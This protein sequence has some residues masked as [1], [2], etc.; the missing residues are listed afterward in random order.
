MFITF[1]GI[2]GCGKSTQ[3]SLIAEF[4]E[5]KNKKV[6]CFREPGGTLLAEQIRQI[7]LNS[8]EHI[9]P[10]AELLL[11]NSARANLVEE[12]IKPAIANGYIVLCDRFYDSTTAYQGYGRM[13]PIEDVVRCNMFATGGFKPD[14]TFLLDLPYKI[15]LERSNL[16]NL[17]RM[18]NAGEDF[19]N[20]VIQGYRIIANSEPERVYLIDSTATIEKVKEDII[21][22]LKIKLNIS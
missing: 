4:L 9:S 5:Q 12:K 17:D 11:F 16:R 1:E 6:M 22:I 19:F 18:E 15:S 3:L 20:R 10:V 7:L 21:S 13:L 2:D 8:S 14:L